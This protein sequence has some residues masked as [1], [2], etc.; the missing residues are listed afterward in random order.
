M[1]Y[2]EAAFFLAAGLCACGAYALMG[3]GRDMDYVVV[4]LLIGSG[5][6][7]LGGYWL[8]EIDKEHKLDEGMR[9]Q[10]R[11]AE[12]RDERDAGMRGD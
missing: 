9:E 11:L 4:A 2:L 12:K 1:S 8:S 7:A 10:K 5:V 3:R 6:C